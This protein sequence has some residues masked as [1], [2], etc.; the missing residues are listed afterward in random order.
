MCKVKLSIFNTKDDLYINFNNNQDIILV[1]GTPGSGKS[2]LAKELSIK[3]GFEKVSLDLVLG[4]ERDQKTLLEQTL[5]D[6]FYKKYPHWNENLFKI[7]DEQRMA[8][9]I[10]LFYDYLIEENQRQNNKIIIEGYYFANFIDI[11]KI[12]DKA[13]IIKRTNMITSIRRRQKREIVYLKKLCDERVIDKSS[14]YY[15]VLSL[16]KYTIINAF[17]WYKELNQFIENIIKKDM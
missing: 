5:L 1:T 10:N 8:Y 12:K 16:K 7:E 13:I 15:Q 2:T 4:Y 11:D 9:Y 14:Y 6:K 3:S 17:K